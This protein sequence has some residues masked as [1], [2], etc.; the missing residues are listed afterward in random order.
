MTPPQAPLDA[1]EFA[2]LALWPRRLRI[3]VAVGIG[4]ML[5]ALAGFAFGEP[6]WQ[7][8]LASLALA[9]LLVAGFSAQVIVRCPRCRRPVGLGTAFV[10]PQRCATCGVQLATSGDD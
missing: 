6:A 5:V 1:Q 2:R 4:L 10:L 7:V 8:P 3:T 9:M